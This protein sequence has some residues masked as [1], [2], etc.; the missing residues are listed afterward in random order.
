MPIICPTVLANNPHD[1]RAQMERIAPFAERIQI[2]LSDGVFSPTTTIAPIQTWWP[3]S[4]QAD[5]HL[6][7]A[8]P[9]EQ[10]ETLVSLKPNMVIIHA[11]AEGDLRGMME[12]LQK[13]NIKAGVALLAD[14]TVESARELVRAAD[15]VLLFAG[16]LGSFGG[17]ADL[18]V[19][20]KVAEVHAINPE[21]E[22]GWDGGANATNA[23]QLTAGGIDV[24][25][26]GSGIQR[27][28]DPS[29]AYAELMKTIS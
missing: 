14:T 4:L 27:A 23:A 21:V 10:L 7:F 11:E 2:D 3:E 24:I 13:L 29:V 5:I 28:E 19:L 22:I 15:H 18:N 17:N 25:N 20:N 12:H 26:V 6:M 1:F 9:L 8:K 16:H